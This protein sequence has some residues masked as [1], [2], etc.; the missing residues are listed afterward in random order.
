MTTRPRWRLALPVW[1]AATWF[2]VSCALPT[3]DL[4]PRIDRV[5]FELAWESESA[6]ERDDGTLRLTTNDGATVDITE[7]YLS[8]YAASLAPC[9]PATATSLLRR[10]GPA[11][12]W[13]GH[14]NDEGLA[15]AAG[16][17]EQIRPQPALPLATLETP[18]IAYCRAHWVAA[19]ADASTVDAEALDMRGR[20][21]RIR[22]RWQQHGSNGDFD[23]S[24]TVASGALAELPAELTGSVRVRVVRPL[25]TLFDG[26]DFATT[27]EATG[28]R[29]LL[30]AL[31]RGT[32]LES[33][34][35]PQL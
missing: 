29:E 1:L 15:T 8:T 16:R 3:P 30:L 21:L 33:T 13:A 22:G 20:V 18:P 14:G 10:I 11:R 9:V 12:A 34:D 5:F 31:A 6:V 35:A 4:G 28:T 25:D 32:R 24:S 7:G 2:A 19:P 26:I 23:W 17:I 27:T